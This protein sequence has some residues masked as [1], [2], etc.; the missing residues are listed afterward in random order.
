MYIMKW[1][2]WKL[3]ISVVVV[4]SGMG[5]IVYLF[6]MPIS[7]VAVKNKAVH[8]LETGNAKLLCQLADP[9]ELAK[10]NLTPAN[11]GQFLRRTLWREGYPKLIEKRRSISPVDEAIWIFNFQ[12]EKRTYKMTDFAI[13]VIDDPQ[14]GWKLNLSRILWLATMAEFGFPEGRAHYTPLAQQLQIRG[15]R[16]RPDIYSFI[17]DDGVLR[18]EESRAH[19]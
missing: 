9:E 6:S 3:W 2:S 8:A 19:N 17:G 7:P 11:T 4:I 10:L 13:E 16:N 15:L 5:Y 18:S 1:R 12:H 14:K